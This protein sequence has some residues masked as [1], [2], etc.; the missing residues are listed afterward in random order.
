MRCTGCC[1]IENASLFTFILIGQW[2]L[3]DAMQGN[4]GKFQTLADFHGHDF[5]RIV[6]RFEVTGSLAY[7]KGQ[8][9]ALQ[10]SGT[11]IDHRVIMA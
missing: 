1:D 6:T 11:E 9:F 3:S 2:H 5:D 10:G 4:N 8:I 7:F